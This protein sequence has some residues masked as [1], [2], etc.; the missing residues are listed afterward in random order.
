MLIV[1]SM[2]VSDCNSLLSKRP[3]G[4][5]SLE[6]SGDVGV[7]GTACYREEENKRNSQQQIAEVQAAIF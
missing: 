7:Q 2:E 5:Q 3:D 4:G 6:G 1:K